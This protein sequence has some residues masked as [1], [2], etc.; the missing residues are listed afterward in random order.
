MGDHLPRPDPT[1]VGR[2]HEQDRLGALLD[3]VEWGDGEVALVSG[4]A[5][6]GKTTL[7]RDL[8]HRADQRGWVVLQGGCYDLTATPPYGPWIDIARSYDAATG[9]LPELPDQLRHTDGIPEISS[10]AVFFELFQDFFA[11]ISNQIPLL[12]VIEDLHWS[13]PASLEV[14][15]FIGRNCANQSI[16]V[17]ATYRDDELSSA[18]ELSTMLPSLV[19]ESQPERLH[20][21]PLDRASMRAFVADRYGLLRQDLDRLVD[22]LSDRADGNPFF[23]SEILQ[24]L[25]EEQ[26]LWP[27]DSGWRLGDLDVARVPPLLRQVIDARLFRTRPATH[28][29]LQVAAV[30]GQEIRFGVWSDVAG[31]SAAELDAVLSEALEALLIEE[32]PGRTT[33]QFRHAL[34]REALY[35]SLTLNHRRDLHRRVGEALAD[36]SKAEPDSIAHHFQQAR[37]SRAKEWLIRAGEHAQ[38]SYAWKTASDRFIQALE[39]IGEDR[40][41]AA[42]RGWLFYRAGRLIRH[43]DHGRARSYLEQAHRLASAIGDDVLSAYALVDLG[44]LRWLS[45]D[46]RR[47]LKDIAEGDQL[48]DELPGDHAPP[49]SSVA[50]WIA[51]ALPATE[52]LKAPDEEAPRSSPVINTRRGTHASFSA[53]PGHFALAKAMGET[54]LQRVATVQDPSALLLGSIGDAYYALAVCESAL[55]NPG[56]SWHWFERSLRTFHAIDHHFMI[57]LISRFHLYEVG[58]TY[59]AADIAA[60]RRLSDEFER[61]FEKSVGAHPP[62]LPAASGTLPLLFLE[63]HWIE[64]RRVAAIALEQNLDAVTS[65]IVHALLAETALHQGDNA[66]AEDQIRKVLPDGPET[67]PGDCKFAAG[68]HLQRTA[69]LL[70]F[71]AQ[72]LDRAQA[73]AEAHDRWLAWNGAVLGRAEGQLLWAHFHYLRA[74]RDAARKHAGAALEYSSDPRQPRVQLA[75]H[76][77]LGMLAAQQRRFNE[78]EQH[79]SQA[80]DLAQQCNAPFERALTLMELSELRL[81]QGRLVPARFAVEEARE[82]GVSLEAAP[83]LARVEELIQRIESSETERPDG[84]T[85]REMDVLRLLAADKSNREIADDLFLSVR[86]IERHIANIYSKINVHNRSEAASYAKE[87]GLTPS[88]PTQPRR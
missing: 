85:P 39:W 2:K 74:E 58:V 86:T 61:A 60:R 73:W 81:K 84:L 6:I 79:L 5:G 20:L 38:R 11:R 62:N 50:A 52:M 13:D 53:Q 35:E 34:L 46:M 23:A 56:Q 64:V 45:G 17:L 59:D 9:G 49:G 77:L 76:R 7:V 30:I 31:L 72:D 80:L 66:T 3:S 15:R 12:I 55:G 83:M 88:E 75:A 26:L 4:E 18:H 33:L 14:L 63:G 16:L 65:G 29:A 27:V 70:A 57:T 28:S 78:A 82:I 10:Q 8:V 54:Y 69:C 25:E 36:Q 40:G 1:I 21:G 43:S 22:H 47:G 71:G 41:R 48:L 44:L 42:E 37:D 87:R 51:D 32:T 19:R 68:L 24:G 67:E